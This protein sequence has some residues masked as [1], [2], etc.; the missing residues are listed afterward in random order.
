QQS[1]REQ[2][3]EKLLP[4]WINNDSTVAVHKTKISLHKTSRQRSLCCLVKSVIPTSQRL[5][6]TQVNRSHR[7]AIHTGNPIHERTLFESPM[8]LCK[9]SHESR[10][11]GTLRAS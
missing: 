5:R 11:I 3:V 4:S 1:D 10:W 9:T 2:A 6:A 8:V 7:I